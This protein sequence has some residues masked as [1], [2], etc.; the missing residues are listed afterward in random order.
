[1][2]NLGPKKGVLLGAYRSVENAKN[3]NVLVRDDI[4]QLAKSKATAERRTLRNV[5]ECALY[6]YLGGEHLPIPH[7]DDEGMRDTN[8]KR[9]G[10]FEPT[11]QNDIANREAIERARAREESEPNDP[12]NQ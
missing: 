10:K 8:R 3:R 5:I 2:S 1:M 6:Y 7:P 11:T 4:W 9:G 12:W